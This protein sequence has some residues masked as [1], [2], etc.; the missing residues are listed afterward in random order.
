M[1]HGPFIDGPHPKRNEVPFRFRTTVGAPLMVRD[2]NVSLSCGVLR[3][4]A[5]GN[6]APLAKHGEVRS[7]KIWRNLVKCGALTIVWWWFKHIL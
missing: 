2:V 6:M 4:P 3:Q 5:Q 7:R 1:E